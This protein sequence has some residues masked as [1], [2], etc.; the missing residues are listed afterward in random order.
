ML[1]DEQDATIARTIIT[2]AQ[3]LGLEVIAEGVELDEQRLFLEKQGCYLYQGYLF[4]KPLPEAHF[5]SF[6]DSRLSK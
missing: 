2:L 4:S 1:D 3:N 5:K 6:I